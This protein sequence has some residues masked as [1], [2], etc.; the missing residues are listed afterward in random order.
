MNKI[1]QREV[2]FINLGQC[3]LE[4]V[5]DLIVSMIWRSLGDSKKVTTFSGLWS[6]SRDTE[7]NATP[8]YY[9][10]IWCQKKFFPNCHDIYQFIQN[11]MQIQTYKKTLM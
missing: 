2:C 6:F 3:T 10:G 9:A 7:F 8:F 5:Q 1:G 11:L 4:C